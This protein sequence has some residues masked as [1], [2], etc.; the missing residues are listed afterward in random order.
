MS[1]PAPVVP[2][3]RSISLNR[4]L[5]GMI[6]GVL[7]VYLAQRGISLE[8]AGD[9]L[10]HAQA[11][12]LFLA[13]PW[14]ALAY[15]AR[16]ARWRRSFSPDGRSRDIQQTFG[17]LM[18]GFTLNNLLPA[19]SG[20]LARVWLMHRYNRIAA[21]TTLAT[22]LVERILDGAALGVIGVFSLQA[23]YGRAFPW[24]NQVA[25]LFYAMFAGLL[26]LPLFHNYI[27]ACLE[28]CERR[29][30]SPILSAI[31]RG[32]VGTLDHTRSLVSPTS[33]LHLVPITF[34]VWGFETIS[35][36]VLMQAFGLQLKSSQIMGFLAIVN[37]ASL[38]PTPGGLGAVE[39][40]GTSAL[41]YCGIERDSAFMLVATLHALQ[42]L[43]CLVLGGLYAW[44]FSRTLGARD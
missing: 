35:C 40:A 6:L 14:L 38:V 11:S 26:A 13:V 23:S 36:S 43:F 21:P 12:S 7:S 32:I 27:V 3:W 25:W 17:L 33:L 28:S 16:S 39:L 5:F 31:N 42:Y 29:I 19:R 41:T 30:P 8:R 34:L 44:R 22:L 24:L 2:F 15:L 10:R 1:T 37:F 9:T 18:V 20:D 4:W